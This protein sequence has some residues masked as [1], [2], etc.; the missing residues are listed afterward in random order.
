LIPK[1]TKIGS[2]DIIVGLLILA[3]GGYIIYRVTVGLNYKWDWAAIPQYLYRYD[4]E[5]SEWVPNLGSVYGGQSLQRSL[6]Q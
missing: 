6:A 2:L 3:V 1:K 4:A 5:R